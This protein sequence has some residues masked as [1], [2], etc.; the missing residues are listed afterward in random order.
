MSPSD[1]RAEVRRVRGHAFRPAYQPR[2]RP[3]FYSCECGAY[4]GS[5]DLHSRAAAMEKHRAHKASVKGEK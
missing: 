5:S 4:L 2:V 1:E 3:G